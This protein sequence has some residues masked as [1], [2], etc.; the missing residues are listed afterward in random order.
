[1]LH[2]LNIFIPQQ[3]K[4][5]FVN[6]ETF[7]MLSLCENKRNENFRIGNTVKFHMSLSDHYRKY[8]KKLKYTYPFSI[9]AIGINCFF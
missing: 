5:L 7:K 2:E 8:K 9:H 1:M 4:I 3:Q 6:V